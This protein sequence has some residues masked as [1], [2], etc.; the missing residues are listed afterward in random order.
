MNTEETWRDKLLHDTTIIRSR[1][2]SEVLNKSPLC[3]YGD[4]CTDD[5]EHTFLKCSKWRRERYAL[6]QQL[7]IDKVGP[8][9]LTNILICKFSELELHRGILN[10]GPEKNGSRLAPH[11]TEAQ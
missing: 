2:F 7:G 4:G 5:A 8:N 9:N 10:S 6:Q 3:I 11:N 1:V